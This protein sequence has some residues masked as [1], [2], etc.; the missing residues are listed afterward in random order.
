MSSS[1]P[2][3]GSARRSALNRAARAAASSSAWHTLD[4]SRVRM[5]RTTTA[6]SARSVFADQRDQVDG[7]AIRVSQGGLAPAH[8]HILLDDD[9]R[10]RVASR[11]RR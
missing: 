5:S 6:S 8:A 3:E 11:R 7:G 2:L 4:S 10:E 9:A 1:M